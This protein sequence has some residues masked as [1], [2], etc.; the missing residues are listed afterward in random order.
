MC[1]ARNGNTLYTVAM[2]GT[3][4]VIFPPKI[5]IQI[6]NHSRPLLFVSLN[7]IFFYLSI[8]IKR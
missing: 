7:I 2:D 5:S 6:L 8:Q 3:L 4:K 1:L